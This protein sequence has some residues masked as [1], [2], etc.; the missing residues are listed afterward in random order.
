LY[1]FFTVDFTLRV[2]SE[3]AKKEKN[4]AILSGDFYNFAVLITNTSPRMASQKISD[5]FSIFIPIY[6][7]TVRLAN[8][9]FTSSC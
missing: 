9:Y 3:A 4:S 7:F 6:I 1:L 5:T 8:E 2:G